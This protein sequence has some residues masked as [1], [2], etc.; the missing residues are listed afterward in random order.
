MTRIRATCPH[1]GEVDLRPDDVA[2][3]IHR[4]ELEEVAEGSIYRFSCPSCAD[5]VRKPADERI[6]RLL[7]DGGVH[8]TVVEAGALLTPEERFAA[9]RLEHPEHPD[10]GPPL[11]PDDLLDFHEALA[12][13]GDELVSYIA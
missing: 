7:T 2:L 8:V 13:A 1:C 4:D 12:A 11:T 3:E 6:A 10:H 9:F 5:E